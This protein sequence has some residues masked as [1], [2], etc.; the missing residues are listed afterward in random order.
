MH[1]SQRDGRTGLPVLFLLHPDVYSF[2]SRYF[3][4]CVPMS[5]SFAPDVFCLCVPMSFLHPDAF[6][7]CIP[8]SFLRAASGHCRLYQLRF[9]YIMYTQDTCFGRVRNTSRQISCMA[10]GRPARGLSM[11]EWTVEAPAKIN[12]SLDVLERLPNGYH[13]LAMIMQTIGLTDSIHLDKRAS[14]ISLAC[15]SARAEEASLVPVDAKNIAWKAA[16]AFLERVPGAGVHIRLE[17]RIPAAAGLAGG[18]TDAA[19]VLSGL[20]ELH[21][22]PLS[23]DELAQIGVRLGA[24]VPYCLMGGTCLSEGIGEILTKLPSFS[25]VW[26]VLI[27]PIFPVSTPWVFSHLRLDDLGERPDTSRLVEAVSRRDLA[28]L[29]QGMRNVL[30]S[31]TVPEYPEIARIREKLLACGAQGSRMSGSGPSVFGLFAEEQGAQGALEEMKTQW[32]DSWAVQTVNGPYG[33]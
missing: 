31:V 12:L 30:E 7:F 17:K 33:L 24:D 2:A 4:F 25:D 16:A 32:P 11:R 26:L 13:R 19:A 20:N 15:V 28:T 14:G 23:P 21:G 1:R 27:K 5:S 9:L 10:Y 29:A 8:M 3:F 18:S 6:F 22:S